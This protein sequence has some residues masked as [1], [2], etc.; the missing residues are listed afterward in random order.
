MPNPVIIVAV[1]FILYTIQR[2]LRGHSGTT[3]FHV[4]LAFL[5]IA[6]LSINSVASS[7]QDAS[8]LIQAIV[9]AAALAVTGA[10]SVFKLTAWRAGART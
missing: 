6:S 5:L 3:W 4:L 2:A 1:I 8:S 10:P 9:V 7:A